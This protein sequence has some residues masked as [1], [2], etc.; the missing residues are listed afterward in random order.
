MSDWHKTGLITRTSW[1]VCLA[2]PPPLPDNH[3]STQKGVSYKSIITWYQVRQWTEV[4]Q[5]RILEFIFRGSYCRRQMTFPDIAEKESAPKCWKMGKYWKL[6]DEL[7]MQPYGDS[8]GTKI[9]SQYLYLFS[10]FYQRAVK[11]LKR[12]IRD[13]NLFIRIRLGLYP[14]GVIWFN[15]RRAGG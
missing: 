12:N 1:M 2:L 3:R 15:F 5:L 13:W 7:L 10:D 9:L 6:Y 11:S 8:E 4:K 14:S